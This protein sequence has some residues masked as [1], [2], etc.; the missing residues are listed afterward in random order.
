M[1]VA[2]WDLGDFT[3]IDVQALAPDSYLPGTDV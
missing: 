3:Y 2:K 1:I